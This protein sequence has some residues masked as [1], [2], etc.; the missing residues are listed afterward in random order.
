[1]K[2]GRKGAIGGGC[3]EGIRKAIIAKGDH[4]C[5]WVKKNLE[6]MQGGRRP[7][8][9]AEWLQAWTHIGEL[10]EVRWVTAH[11]KEKEDDTRAAA[12]GGGGY[13]AQVHRLYPGADA[14]A[15]KGIKDPGLWVK[16]QVGA[17]KVKSH[18]RRWGGVDWLVRFRKQSRLGEGLTNP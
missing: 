18:L 3:P 8:H 11:A 14:L 4:A 17:Q 10:I 9:Q 15:T 7:W 16:R 2:G 5:C 6:V 1:M 12:G 13:P